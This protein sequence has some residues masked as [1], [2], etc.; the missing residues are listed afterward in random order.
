MHDLKVSVPVHRPDLDFLVVLWQNLSL[1]LEI[2]DEL[3]RGDILDL[4]FTY[5]EGSAVSFPD[6]VLDHVVLFVVEHH[7]N[8]PLS[9]QK[10]HSLV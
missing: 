5:V 4:D 6:L 9:R 7:W 1:M 3:L 10:L 8:L 2:V